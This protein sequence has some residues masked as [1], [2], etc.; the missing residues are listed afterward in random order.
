MHGS[1]RGQTY[2]KR[3]LGIRVV[4]EEGGSIGYGRAFG[5]YGIIFLLGILVVP[6]LID[7]LWPLWDDRS[8]ALHDKGVRSFVVRA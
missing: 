2:G 1:R 6:L 5:R 3:A 7:Y 4:N 8:Q